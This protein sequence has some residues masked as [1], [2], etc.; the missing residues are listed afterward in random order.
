MKPTP[1]LGEQV[2][3]P[4]PDS[5]A[6]VLT[7]GRGGCRDCGQQAVLKASTTLSNLAVVALLNA[8]GIRGISGM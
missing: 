3:T 5:E 1:P 8:S 2:R 7:G 4:A 6:F